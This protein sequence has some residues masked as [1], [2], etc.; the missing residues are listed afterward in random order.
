MKL[1]FVACCV[2]VSI[3]NFGARGD[4]ADALK[5]LE[6]RW[7][8]GDLRFFAPPPEIWQMI[9]GRELS[10]EN[11][12]ELFV[13]RALL[14]ID[15]DQFVFRNQKHER[16]VKV[17]VDATK[18]PKQIDFLLGD[19]KRLLAIYEIDDRRLGLRIGDAKTRPEK[20]ENQEVG[21]KD[22]RIGFQRQRD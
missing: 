8:Q 5:P 13:N 16:R 20:F 3:L 15:G 2:L 10:T 11:P 17:K 22:F 21:K 7:A 14:A 18:N 9:Y 19:D 1:Q 4:D 6:G 12:I